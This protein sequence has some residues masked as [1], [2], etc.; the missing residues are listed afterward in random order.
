M[1]L[2]GTIQGATANILS[3][4]NVQ[5]KFKVMYNSTL[6]QVF[7]VHKA[8]VTTTVVRPSK[9]GLFFADF[10]KDVKKKQTHSNEHSS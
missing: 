6:N 1:V 4:S 2:Y 3:L 9:R 8:D 10:K 5:K 7:V